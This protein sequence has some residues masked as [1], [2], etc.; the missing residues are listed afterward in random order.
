MGKLMQAGIAADLDAAYQ[1]ATRAN[2]EIYAEMMQKEL[3][4][5]LT[6]HQ[7][8]ALQR[9]QQARKAAVSPSGRAPSQA[10]PN[11]KERPKGVRGS[12]LAAIEEV[13]ESQRA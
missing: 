8:E 2:P 4:T 13:R 6:A 9:S 12:V 1:Q 11:G 3:D 7:Q 10:A 5:R